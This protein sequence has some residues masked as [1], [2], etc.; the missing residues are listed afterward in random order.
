MDNSTAEYTF[1]KAFFNNQQTPPHVDIKIATIPLSPDRAS[2]EDD[3]TPG[4]E[5]GDY[6]ER[7]GTI[8]T[9]STSYF[10]HPTPKKDVNVDLMWKQIMEP[11]L[12]YCQ[13]SP[14]FSTR[15]SL[16]IP[17]RTL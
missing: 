14:F 16:R 11:V 9:S 2:Y 15:A 4:S 12:E 17:F 3:K 13:V 10:P 1:I 5:I 8:A 6:P 7:T